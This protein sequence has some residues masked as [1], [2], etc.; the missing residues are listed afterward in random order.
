M[1]AAAGPLRGLRVLDACDALAV[2]ATKL[3][4]NLGAEVIRLE[5][6]TGDPMRRFP[7][8]IDGISAYFEHFNAGK[9]SITLDLTTAAG[10]AW[11]ESLV[12]SCNAVL[13]S[14]QAA[15]LLSSRAGRERLT[16]ARRDLVLVSVTPFGLHGPKAEQRGGDLIAA[17][18]SGL[19]ALNGRP[20]APPYRPGG[21]Q[22][23]HMAGLLAANAALLGLFEQQCKG[24]GCH[25]EVPVNFAAALSTLQTANANYYTWHGRVPQRRGLGLSGY[26]SLFRT[27]DGWV[28]LIALPG[29]W[30]K[31]AGLLEEHGAAGDLAEAGYDDA[32]QRLARAEHINELIG[33]FTS[34]FGKEELQT[35]T[36][37][38][39]VAC[40]PVNSVADLAADPFLQ[41][42]GFFRQVAH[43]GWERTVAYPAPP[44]HFGERAIGTQQPAPATGA[45]N[46]AIWVEELG[47][48][49]VTLAELCDGAAG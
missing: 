22:A 40:T 25:V 42:R 24:H 4:L 1:S 9:R 23:A 33:A 47:M 12:A 34:R 13:E 10:L 16:R 11:L 39:G 44:W 27:R 31:L 37:R 41:Q 43:P 30:S 15:E 21:E 46:R 36:Q 5:P 32:E 28:V 29:Q 2:Y 3:L 49:A 26:R 18:E 14:G 19:L 35:L 38:A 6:P 7:P 48:D 8:L 20:D 45:D 17:A